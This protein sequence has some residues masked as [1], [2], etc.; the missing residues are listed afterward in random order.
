MRRLLVSSGVVGLPDVDSVLLDADRI[1]AIGRRAEFDGTDD[2]S[3]HDGF[4]AAPRHEYRGSGQHPSPCSS[5][6]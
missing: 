6:W 1:L 3:E 5:S 2:V 4:L